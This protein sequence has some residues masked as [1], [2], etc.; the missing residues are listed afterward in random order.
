[1]SSYPPRTIRALEQL[2]LVS[3]LEGDII[4]CG[5][6]RGQT[7][8][9]MAMYLKRNGIDKK[10][11]A[12]DTYGGLPYDGGAIDPDLKAGEC[13]ADFDTFW[14]N[15]KAAG[16]EDYIIPIQGLVE[17]TLPAEFASHTF[18][19]AFL[20]LDLYEPT[21]FCA[22]FLALKIV[23]GGVMGFHDYKFERCPGIEIVVDQEVDK[24]LYHKYGDTHGNCA[25]LQR[26][27]S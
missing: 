7:T 17:E 9:A 19:L 18:C 8:I 24:N 6:F 21:S 10:I 13:T 20:D 12:C 15:V 27:R 14:S 22:K 5:V 25:W 23:R 4:E 26:R 11:Y 16:V 1:M 3:G 2:R